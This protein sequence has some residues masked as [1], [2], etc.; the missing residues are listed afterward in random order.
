[1]KAGILIISKLVVE[2]KLI[3]KTILK[4]GMENGWLILSKVNG[5]I[6]V[7]NPIQEIIHGTWAIQALKH[8]A[9]H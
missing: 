6:T 5:I 2:P 3:L 1:M 9:H 8:I 4:M 7:I